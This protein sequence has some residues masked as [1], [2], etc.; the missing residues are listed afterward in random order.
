MFNVVVKASIDP[1]KTD[2][3]VFSQLY[4]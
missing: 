1:S 4:Y 2:S 3:H